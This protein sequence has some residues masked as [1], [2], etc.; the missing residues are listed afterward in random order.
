VSLVGF[1]ARNHPQQV[2]KRGA[3]LVVDERVTPPEWFAELHARFRFT[4]DAAALPR[5]AKLLRFFDPEIDGLKQP[6]S[7][8]RVFCNPPFSALEPWVAKAHQETRAA[9]IVMLTPSNRTEQGWWQTYIEP[10]R[11]RGGRLRTE[12]L[13]SRRRFIHPE[14]ERVGMNERPAFGI[15]LLIW[16]RQTT[17]A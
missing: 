13:R 6:W 10:Y 2:R 12:F 17:G 5:N 9:V 14:A 15:C 3:L 4:V 7:H 11:D 1:K 8:E 16:E